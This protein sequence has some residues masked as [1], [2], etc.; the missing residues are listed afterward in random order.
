[1][2]PLVFDDLAGFLLQRHM[3]RLGVCHDSLVLALGL[4][5]HVREDALRLCRHVG[6][7]LLVVLELA[8]GL[9]L[10]ALSG[11]DVASDALL[12]RD[13]A[14]ADGRAA[15]AP[16]EVEQDGRVQ[17]QGAER[18]RSPR[19]TPQEARGDAFLFA[20]EAVKPVDVRK[21]R[22]VVVAAMPVS[23]IAVSS[24]AMGSIT[25]ATG[26]LPVLSGVR[27]H[28]GSFRAL[29]RPVRS[30]LQGE[31][32]KANSRRE[33]RQANELAGTHEDSSR[34]RTRAPMPRTSSS[35]RACS[36]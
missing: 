13:Q 24:V 17:Q 8:L 16:E 27:R 33:N 20:K 7:L 28:V 10:H 5:A 22:G 36:S 35:F 29:V 32:P 15:E 4:S 21:G 6:E 26:M 30:S 2:R 1:M 3:P 31:R 9:F 18:N 14:R 12:A 23:S 11:L 19:L 25:M 34:P